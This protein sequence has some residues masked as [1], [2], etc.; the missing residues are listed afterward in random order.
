MANKRDPG[1]RLDINMYT[2]GHKLRGIKKLPLTLLDA[3]RVT[4]KSKV[5]R[6]GLGD[7]LMDAY[8]KLKLEE[9]HRYTGHLSAW[10]RE[11]TLDC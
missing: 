11:N 4:E 10:E 9:W 2:E 3:L 5:L 6:Q 8:L 7:K 1:K